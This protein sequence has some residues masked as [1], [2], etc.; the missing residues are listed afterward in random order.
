MK[1]VDQYELWIYVSLVEW[2]NEAWS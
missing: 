2:F 1:V